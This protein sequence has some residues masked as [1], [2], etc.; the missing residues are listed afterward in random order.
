MAERSMFFDTTLEQTR[1]YSASDWANYF[2][3]L[4]E[5]GIWQEELDA[6]TLSN[7]GT[8]MITTVAGGR[9][10]LL[11]YYYE[12]DSP[13]ELQHDAADAVNSR[14]DRIVVRLDKANY[15]ISTI[16]LKG[17][18][19]VIPTAPA[20]TRTDDIYDISLGQA[21]VPAASS[22]IPSGNI[23][24]ERGIAG[25]GDYARYKTK[26]AWYPK[27]QV[28][29]DAWMYVHFPNELTNQEKADIE[30]NQSLMGIINKQGTLSSFKDRVL[31]DLD[32]QYYDIYSLYMES[33]Y[34]G[35][36][37][38]SPDVNGAKAILF[39][40]FMDSS[41]VGASSSNVEVDTYNDI[42]KPTAKTTGDIRP[43]SG[44]AGA[45]TNFSTLTGAWTGINL[46][47]TMDNDLATY[48]QS[49]N[50]GNNYPDYVYKDGTLKFELPRP[51]NTNQVIIR[52][53]KNG[54]FSS[55]VNAYI[56]K[57]AISSD[58]VNWTT[59]TTGNTTVDTFQTLKD[60][61]F[62]IGSYQDFKYIA[63]ATRHGANNGSGYLN[64]ADVRVNAALDYEIGDFRID[65]Q[66]LDFNPLAAKLFVSVQTSANAIVIPS[67]SNNSGA[68]F[69]N[70]N[71]IAYRNDP[72]F[73]EF[74]EIEYEIDLDGTSGVVVLKMLLNPDSFNFPRIKRY[75]LYFI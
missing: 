24:D 10:L 59:I 21:L 52:A 3:T 23:T 34:L 16:I 5:S 57:V 69:N 74:T 41:G 73:P 2:A 32:N 44:T 61:V 18:P 58:G 14:I 9:A 65:N 67:I 50:S 46:S 39:D 56:T 43:S 6:F 54:S 72:K 45:I 47:N 20:I 8:N 38:N 63:I 37:S 1:Q 71:M 27:N 17:V 19:D 30:A 40:G 4:I 53:T 70:M 51:V 68:T 7:T 35:N 26:P 48:A 42:L 75:G 25:L 28:P 49:V 29:Q 66:A 55:S 33:Y 13:L 22:I 11:G 60:F 31:T 36:M 64:L 15:K 62:N 12:N